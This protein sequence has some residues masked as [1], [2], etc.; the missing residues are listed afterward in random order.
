MNKTNSR[1]SYGALTGSAPVSSPTATFWN[2]VG[3][4]IV[5]LAVSMFRASNFKLEAAN[6]KLEVNRAVEEIKQVSDD[7]ENTVRTLPKPKREKIEQKLEDFNYQL[8]ETQQK[9]LTER[10]ERTSEDS[11]G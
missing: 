4:S 5:I 6:Q 2:C 10:D 9:I 7:L 8:L 11:D 1:T 3:I